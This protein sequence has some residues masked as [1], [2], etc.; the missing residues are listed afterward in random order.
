MEGRRL[1]NPVLPKH[2]PSSS[3]LTAADRRTESRHYT[4]GHLR[5]SFDDPSPQD[6]TGRL[7]DY[8]KSG[9]RAMH[10]YPA[11]HTGQIA[12][13]RHLLAFGQTREIGN[14]SA[15]AS[16]ETGFLVIK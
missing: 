5:F 12:E 6:I 14:R 8:S 9:F 3:T 10:D 13:F 15:D 1:E 4:E 16:A 7:M 11:L 2:K